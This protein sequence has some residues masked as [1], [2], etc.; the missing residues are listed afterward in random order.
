MEVEKENLVMTD[1]RLCAIC[2]KEK[3]KYCCPCCGLRTCSLICC[4]KHK[5]ELSCPG[6]CDS[7]KYC[8][9]DEYNAL[10]FQKDYR[11]LEDIDRKNVTRKKFLMKVNPKN[12][13]NRRRKMLLKLA[14]KCKINLRLAPSSA[15]LRAQIN[16]TWIDFSD[17]KKLY[18]SVEFN[19]IPMELRGGTNTLQNFE[20]LASKC[21]RLVVHDWEQQRRLSEIWTEKI[22]NLSPEQQDALIIRAA[23]DL[24]SAGKVMF[25]LN[26]TENRC[27]FYILTQKLGQ[28][29]LTNCAKNPLHFV[30]IFSTNRLVDILVTPGLTVFELPTIWVSP[31]EII[32]TYH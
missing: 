21:L 10:H 2:L 30:R 24:P 8:R 26:H 11:L 32:N 13:Q 15:L 29:S 20:S 3:H 22:V 14:T 25:W 16:Q 17:T 7:V 23:S 6:L 18:W 5:S 9:R 12:E 28:E 4:D 1:N 19:F 27:Y 31:F